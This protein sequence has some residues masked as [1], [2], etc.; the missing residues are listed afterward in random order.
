MAAL[1]KLLGSR[2]FQVDGDVCIMATG[3]RGVVRYFG[4]TSKDAGDW[5]GI[6]LHAPV[7]NS[8]GALK[9]KQHFLCPPKHGTF[10][11]PA[12]CIE[13]STIEWIA[14]IFEQLQ[15]QPDVVK[16]TES[17]FTIRRTELARI[18]WDQFAQ[19]TSADPAVTERLVQWF[20]PLPLCMGEP[21]LVAMARAASPTGTVPLAA[22]E[23]DSTAGAAERDPAT[24][25]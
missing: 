25:G 20:F 4:P 2:S 13:W 22:A 9:G 7:G 1:P 15:G 24:T 14:A 11:K 3:H 12:K 5:L 23:P 6:E 18:G 10:V 21:L 16:L 19:A 8:T 17:G